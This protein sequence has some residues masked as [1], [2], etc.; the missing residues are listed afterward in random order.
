MVQESSQGQDWTAKGKLRIA[1]EIRV[2]Q[3]SVE[4]HNLRIKFKEEDIGIECRVTALPKA[5]RH[6]ERNTSSAECLNDK[7]PRGIREGIS[8]IN[9]HKRSKQ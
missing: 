6:W 8:F 7:K 1:L 2:N 3:I 4:S 9:G 5:A